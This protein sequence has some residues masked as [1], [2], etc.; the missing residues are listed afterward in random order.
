[1]TCPIPGSDGKHGMNQHMRQTMAVSGIA[2]GLGVGLLWVVSQLLRASGRSSELLT[3]VPV[4]GGASSASTPLP[5]VAAL[6]GGIVIIGTAFAA[7]QLRKSP[8]AAVVVAA[9]GLILAAALIS[10]SS[11]QWSD[12]GRMSLPSGFNHITVSI[13]FAAAVGL[14]MLALVSDR[15]R[16]FRFIYTAALIAL[17]VFVAIRLL[18]K[19]EQPEPESPVQTPTIVAGGGSGDVV[20][21]GSSGQVGE[22]GAVGAGAGPSTSGSGQS[23]IST[24]TAVAGTG[25]NAE[26]DGAGNSAQAGGSDQADSGGSAGSAGSTNSSERRGISSEALR[27]FWNSWL[28]RLLIIVMIV[29][30]VLYLLQLIARLFRWWRTRS[31]RA[32]SA[33]GGAGASGGGSASAY[34]RRRFSWR[35]LIWSIVM[36]IIFS[37]LFAILFPSCGAGGGSGGGGGRGSGS[38]QGQPGSAS[39]GEAGDQGTVGGAGAGGSRAAAAESGVGAGTGLVD[40]G[41]VVAG[42]TAISVGPAASVIT[43]R[44]ASNPTTVPVAPTSTIPVATRPTEIEVE[45]TATFI[46]APTPTPV[47]IEEEEPDKKSINWLLIGLVALI[48]FLLIVAIILLW[49]YLRR[50]RKKKTDEPAL[51]LPVELPLEEP[52]PVIEELPVN[53]EPE[54]PGPEK[55]LVQPPVMPKPPMPVAT[56]LRITFPEVDRPLTGIWGLGDVLSVRCDLES[57][58]GVA[59]PGATIVLS[60]EGHEPNS[61]QTDADGACV[62][63]FTFFNKGMVR[64]SAVFAGTKEL[65]PSSDQQRLEI[66]DYREEVIKLFNGFLARFRRGSNSISMN[67]TPR[68]VESFLLRRKLVSDDNAL[69]SFVAVFEHAEYSL[70]TTRREQ[71]TAAFLAS[72]RL[73]KRGA[74]A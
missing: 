49:W 55:P 73:M 60:V 36:A 5:L 58:D 48:I 62:S 45:P 35:S 53:P 69:S 17:L 59:V 6:V 12:T 38:D 29:I 25:S 2:L 72:E 54:P 21:G 51:E 19:P 70:R 1:M 20:G 27:S 30:A 26:Q 33:T 67:A 40:V 42:P 28:G 44:P 37:L 43:G 46:P 57:V 47:P 3:P 52:E 22:P 34:R 10:I 14:L 23:N 8:F 4:E 7:W 63:E 31:E 24:G 50:R 71:C 56:R 39:G 68:E 41:S 13:I 11:V 74:A 64:F 32:A 65:L 16:W 66:V 9:G 18:D 15:S 61:L